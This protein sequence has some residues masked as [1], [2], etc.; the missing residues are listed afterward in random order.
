MLESIMTA[1]E[2][3]APQLKR[4][5][6]QKWMTEEIL[7][8]MDGRKKKQKEQLDMQKWTDRSERCAS[9]QKKVS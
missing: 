1:T 2:K 7:E 5:G 8:K 6:K 4:R 3:T 9:K